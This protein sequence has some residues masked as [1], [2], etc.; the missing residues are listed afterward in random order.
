MGKGL[1]IFIFEQPA[2]RV[3]EFNQ[4]TFHVI[5]GITERTIDIKQ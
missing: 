3:E 2:H 4:A 5:I 1:G